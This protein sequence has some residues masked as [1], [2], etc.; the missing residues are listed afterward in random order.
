MVFS[1]AYFIIAYRF[2][3][4]SIFQTS[5]SQPFSARDTPQKVCKACSI[6]T[7][8]PRNISKVAMSESD[9]MSK[10][11]QYLRAHLAKSPLFLSSLLDGFTLPDFNVSEKFRTEGSAS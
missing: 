11:A 1:R 3:R 9:F 4:D 8:T 10:L 2:Y 5:G 6:F 7:E